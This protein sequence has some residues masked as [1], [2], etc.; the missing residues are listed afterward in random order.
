MKT[1]ILFFIAITILPGCFSLLADKPAL[2]NSPSV[3]LA[4]N[5]DIVT[6]TITIPGRDY[7]VVGSRCTLTGENQTVLGVWT[8]GNDEFNDTRIVRFNDI[9]QT[10]SLYCE[11]MDR[12]NP[13]RSIS[14]TKYPTLAAAAAGQCNVLCVI[15]AIS[16]VN[17]NCLSGSIPTAYCAGATCVNG[18][19]GTSTEACVPLN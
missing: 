4:R 9:T 16:A 10:Y 13:R 2:T 18:Y 5:N 17:A 8:V 1:Q 19:T 12:G 14:I 11:A 3:Y 6:L 15:G 7:A